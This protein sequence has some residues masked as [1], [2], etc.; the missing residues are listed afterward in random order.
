MKVHYRY[1]DIDVHR[2]KSL[3]AGPHLYYSVFTDDGLECASGYEYPSKGYGVRESIQEWK[4]LVDEV[5]EH[6]KPG[7]SV[8]DAWEDYRP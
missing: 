4:N 2:A 8:E 3:G 1:H 6:R 7:Q 5:M